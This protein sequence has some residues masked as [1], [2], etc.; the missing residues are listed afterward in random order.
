MAGPAVHPSSPA[1][2][3]PRPGGASPAAD[4]PGPAALQRGHGAPGRLGRGQAGFPPR[5]RAGRSR[6]CGV[7][8]AWR[9]RTGRPKS[10]GRRSRPRPRDPGRRLR[11]WTA[12]SRT[13]ARDR[14]RR[15]RAEQA[16]RP[17]GGGAGAAGRGLAASWA[18]SCPG[19]GASRALAAR[20]GTGGNGGMD[21]GSSA[22]S[23]PV[24][25]QPLPWNT[26]S[27]R[28]APTRRLRARPTAGLP[29]TG[30]N[31]LQASR[32]LAP[33]SSGMMHHG[34]G[35]AVGRLPRSATVMPCRG[36][37][38]GD[39]QTEPVASGKV[40]VRRTARSRLISAAAP[41]VCRTRGPP[42]RWRTHR[43]TIPLDADPRLGGEKRS[44]SRSARLAGG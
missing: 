44:R 33:G 22:V 26:L 10:A 16:E 17:A 3:P 11:R 30:P 37:P 27:R 32:R 18:R 13:A 34:R 9:T 1:G 21:G 19:A 38:A 29:A 41:R 15:G 12:R 40:E 6:S 8:L 5:R 31:P 25:G 20:A 14:E 43:R 36:E 28:P 7:R 42:S 2:G 23:R 4:R 39:E 35:A 24:K